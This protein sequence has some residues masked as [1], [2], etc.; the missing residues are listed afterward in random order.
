MEHHRLKDLARRYRT[1][2]KQFHRS[3]ADCENTKQIYD[4]LKKTASRKYK[5]LDDFYNT[6]KKSHKGLDAKTIKATENKRD[7]KSPIY[8]RECV[9]SGTLEKMERRLAMQSVVNI[10]GRVANAVTKHTNFLI[11][12]NNDNCKTIKDGKSSKQKKAEE[13]KAKGYDIEI[14]TE[15]TFYD[16]I[17]K[18]I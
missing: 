14:I 10:G 9:F 4:H 7:E 5:S 8:N 18:E 2:V 16:Y 12:G 3:L 6:F 17:K 15:D 13:Y 11:L 1:S